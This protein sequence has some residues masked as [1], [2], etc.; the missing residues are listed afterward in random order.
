MLTFKPT[1]LSETLGV[2]E[3]MANAY[4]HSLLMEG[5]V[6]DSLSPKDNEQPFC[7][8]HLRIEKK[9]GR[10]SSIGVF[11]LGSTDEDDIENPYLSAVIFMSGEQF[12]PARSVLLENPSSA[13]RGYWFDPS[14]LA[15]DYGCFCIEYILDG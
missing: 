7:H 1:G 6:W 8:G 10:E 13:R 11:R 12:A 2:G 15:V 3:G 5:R 9:D 4:G 14:K